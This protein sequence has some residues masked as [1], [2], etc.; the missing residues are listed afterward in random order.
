MERLRIDR[1]ERPG[2]DGEPRPFP[3]VVADVGDVLAVP[4]D[5]LLR[6][7]EV[8]DRPD[9]AV[10]EVEGRDS[11]GGPSHDPS[12]RQLGVVREG[13]DEIAARD[14][15]RPPRHGTAPR[16]FDGERADE[17]ARRVEDLHA[18][19]REVVRDERVAAEHAEEGEKPVFAGSF[20]FSGRAPHEGSGGIVPAKFAGALVPEDDV[21]GAEADRP[22]DAV[23][24]VV[25]VS[26]RGPDLEQRLLAHGPALAGA[27]R[28][29]DGRG[30]RHAG[31]IRVQ[32]TRRHPRRLAGLYGE[33]G[34]E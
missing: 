20:A 15:E 27:P 22:D 30:D 33:H 29:L 25:R 11:D 26:G 18:P 17:S 32:R 16:R 2:S 1:R 28:R 19:E 4:R 14:A 5:H 23:E 24:F 9:R 34:R 7:G 3:E 21:A 10:G 31:R 13:Y 6:A 12:L 8:R